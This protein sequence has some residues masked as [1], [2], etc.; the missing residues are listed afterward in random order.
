MNGWLGRMTGFG[1]RPAGTPRGLGR[2]SGPRPLLVVLLGWAL[3]VLTLMPTQQPLLAA[4][5]TLVPLG[6][7][8]FLAEE[9]ELKDE[10]VKHGKWTTSSAVPRRGARRRAAPEPPSWVCRL[11]ASLP[12]EPT[13]SDARDGLTPT[14]LLPTPHNGCGAH[15][16]C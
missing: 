4:L 10:E 3:V 16:R 15:L 8:E 5:Q 1:Y 11:R 6:S 2:L 14:G 9:D 13:P 12:A 7:V